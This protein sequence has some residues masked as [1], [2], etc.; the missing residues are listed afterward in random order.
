MLPLAE[1]EDNM[2]DVDLRNYLTRC[3]VFFPEWC[4]LEP[5]SFYGS[6]PQI[7][8]VFAAR[9]FS[10]TDQSEPYNYNDWYDWTVDRVTL[11]VD[12]FQSYGLPSST[13]RYE[14]M[15]KGGKRFS[16]LSKKKSKPL[17]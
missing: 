6:P 17:K 4:V 10:R 5:F 13:A 7:G 1:F 3:T 12:Y 11:V 8:T 15:V 16:N 9:C 14:I 2:A